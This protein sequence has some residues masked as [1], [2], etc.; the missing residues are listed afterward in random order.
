MSTPEQVRAA[1]REFVDRAHAALDESDYYRVLG[2]SSAAGAEEIRTAYYRLAA[3]LHP[4]I[5]GDSVEPEFRLRLTT[6]FSRVVEAYKA[7]SDPR[8]RAEYDEGLAQGMLRLT[9]GLKVRPRPD[10]GI[11]DESARRF[12]Q[13]AEKAMADGDGRAALVN[14]RIALSS[15]PDSPILKAALARAEEMAARR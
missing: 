4:D 5:H 2:V 14:L 8:R 7:L 3:R 12:Y 10:Q 1:I 13:L 9:A 6:V 11:R 15:E